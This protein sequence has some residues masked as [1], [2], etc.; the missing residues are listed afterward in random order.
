[1]DILLEADSGMKEVII[2]LSLGLN[3]AQIGKHWTYLIEKDQD[4]EASG[5]HTVMDCNRRGFTWSRVL[6]AAS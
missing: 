6:I 4:F 1:M 2:F 5:N 3:C